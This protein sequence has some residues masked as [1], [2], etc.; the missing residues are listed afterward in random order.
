MT[1]EGISCLS[2]DTKEKKKKNN[3]KSPRM[4]G[5]RVFSIDRDSQLDLGLDQTTYYLLHSAS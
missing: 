5:M 4:S 1:A 2:R 3:K